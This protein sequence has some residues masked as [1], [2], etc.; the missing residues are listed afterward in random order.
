MKTLQLSFLLASLQMVSGLLSVEECKNLIAC[1]A[2]HSPVCGSDAETY[3][4]K[5][6]LDMK[7]CA[8]R[9]EKLHVA[10]EGSCP[11]RDL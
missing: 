1:T 9:D 6:H 10:S 8:T 7:A 2:D 11:K 5:C 4:N 3:S